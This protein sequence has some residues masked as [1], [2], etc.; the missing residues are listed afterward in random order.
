[1]SNTKV[2]FLLKRRPDFDPEKHTIGGLSTGLYNSANFMNELL[3]DNGVESNLEVCIDNNVIDRFVTKYRPSIAIIEAFWVVPPKFLVLSK[4]HPSV[5][6]I[7]RI[8]SD[9]PFLASEGNSMDWIAEYVKHPNIIVAPN[10]S[11]MFQELRFYLGHLNNWSEEKLNEK[12]IYLP[13]YY[14]QDYKQKSLQ[15]EDG[16]INISCFGAVRPLK[17]QLLQAISAVKFAVSIDRKLRFHINSGRIEMKGEPVLNNLKGLFQ[18]LA[19]NGHEL[20]SHEWRPRDEFLDLCAKMDIGLQ[21]SFNETFNIVAADHI[22]QGVPIIGSTE[23]PW[24]DPTYCADPVDS[25]DIYNKLHITFSNIEQN[26]RSHEDRLTKYTETSK[27]Y[28]LEYFR[29]R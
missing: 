10:S 18:H 14:P 15:L 3:N 4:L 2:L 6:W 28:W 20:I 27:R 9:M 11:R 26:C 1:M 12:V 5:T 19:D 29:K 13:N 7:I 25:H 24:A 21:V 23:I 22:S 17:N 8:H 16:Y